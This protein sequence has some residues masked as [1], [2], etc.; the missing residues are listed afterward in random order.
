VFELY[1]WA[2]K[3]KLKS[4]RTAVNLGFRESGVQGLKWGDEKMEAKVLAHARGF[5][6]IY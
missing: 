6:V 2:G 5:K 4:A 3:M 1:G